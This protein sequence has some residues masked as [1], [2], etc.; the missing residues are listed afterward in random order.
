MIQIFPVIR[1]NWPYTIYDQFCH[2]Q[3]KFFLN[4]LKGSMRV[5]N[6]LIFTRFITVLATAL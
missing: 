4:L 5:F 2:T 1:K 6:Q 3:I